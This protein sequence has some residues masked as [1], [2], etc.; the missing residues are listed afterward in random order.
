MCGIIA[1][2][3]PFKVNQPLAERMLKDLHH[4]G[5]DANGSV[6]R[7]SH[8]LYLGHTR[9]KVIDV[10]NEAN[11]PM[12]S[13]CGRYAVVYNGEIYNFRDIK[14]ELGDF[15]QWRTHS[16]TEVLLHGYRQ[17]GI[18]L[19]SRMN[20]MW[21]FALLDRRIGRLWMSRD[22]FGKKPLYY[23]QNNDNF[24]FS[25]ELRSIAFHPVVEPAIDRLSL[26]KYFA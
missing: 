14:T 18:E 16:D 23:S 9:L 10:S 17:W 22:R 11:Q 21:A 15:W 6:L 19:T 1:L 4:R 8:K 12:L 20:G 24:V 13:P 5:P 3:D 25:S 26:Q 2:F 7:E